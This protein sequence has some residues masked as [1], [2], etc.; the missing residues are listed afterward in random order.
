MIFVYQVVILQDPASPKAIELLSVIK[1]M[2]QVHL[3]P[4]AL[5]V[6]N[7]LKE[8]MTIPNSLPSRAGMK[9]FA[10]CLESVLLQNMKT[11]PVFFLEP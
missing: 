8:V 9:E 11:R 1:K 5:Q 2:H 3:F 7:R 10:V 4:R 6:R